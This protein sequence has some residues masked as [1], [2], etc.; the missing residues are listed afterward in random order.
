M[1]IFLSVE[2]LSLLVNVGTLI[3]AAFALMSIKV[4]KDNIVISSKRDSV[5]YASDLV[6]FYLNDFVSASSNTFKY[7]EEIQINP[8]R[9]DFNKRMK[10][11]TDEEFRDI[12]GDTEAYRIY[13]K[14]SKM[15][16]NHKKLVTMK[17]LEMNLLETFSV[18]FVNGVADEGI[19]FGSIGA[20]FCFSVEDNWLN[21]CSVRTRKNGEFNY[22]N[23]TIKLYNIWADRIKK[24]KLEN[25]KTDIE[26][27]ILRISDNTIKPIGM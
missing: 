11:F 15:E 6:K 22:F 25:N 16:E 19:A 24:F 21:Y 5:K 1:N 7:N 14:L 12:Y 27:E 10:E 8:L 26:E 13:S 23:N 3:V 9:S 4:A 18:P 2:Q 20:S 17:L